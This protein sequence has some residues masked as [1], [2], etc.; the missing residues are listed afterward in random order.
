[1]IINH[2]K[3]AVRYLSKHRTY[4][5]INLLGLSL[6]YLC[7]LMLNIYVVGERNYDSQ[8]AHTYRLIQKDLSDEGNTIEVATIG[9]RV[10][11]ASR[12]QFPEI[13]AVT[14]VGSM[15]RLTVGNEP[16]NLHYERFFTIDSGFFEVFNFQF[17]EGNA[18]QLNNQPN[19]LLLT[20]TLKEKYFGNRPALGKLL[21]T[22]VFEGVVG[23]VIEDFPKNT[24]F[25]ANLMIPEQTTSKI[26]NWYDDFIS[27]S[28]HRNAFLTYF[29]LRD[30]SDVVNLEKKITA[31][32]EENWPVEEKFTSQF[33]LQDVRDIHLY[34]EQVEGEI[35]HQKGN[36]FYVN[37]FFWIG[38]LILLVATFNY[39]GLL[40]MAFMRRS[41]EIGIRKAVGAGKRQL[42]AQLLTE[43][44]LL[45]SVSLLVAWVALYMINPFIPDFF[46]SSF[47]LIALPTSQVLLIGL[48]GIVIS[49]LAIG[50]PSYLV[51]VRNIV[52]SLKGPQV[53]YPRLS[54][55][56]LLI[57]FQF[58]V[59]I[60][61][62]AMTTLLFR[63]VKYLEEKELG[64]NMEGL[65]VVDIN[66]GN[67]RSKFASIKEEFL[68]LPAVQK[69][70]VSSRVPGEW[71]NFPLVDVV[72]SGES[73]PTA[74]QM[75]FIGV[76]QDFIST[77]DINLVQGNNFRGTEFDSTQVL[78]NQAAVSA[79]GLIDPVGHFI[80]I[81][82]VNWSGDTNP[83][84]EPL[85][86]SIAGIVEDFHFEGFQQS[87]QPM[88]MGY[89]K[90][91]I[92]NIDYYSLS[93]NTSNWDA[94]LLAL[95]KINNQFD[96]ENPLE[97]HILND[98]F[99]RFHEPVIQRSQLLLF[100]TWVVVFIAC[101]GLFATTAYT[102][103]IRRKEIGI[104]K[105]LG[106]KVTELIKMISFDFL[107]LV[108][109]G[110][111]IALPLSWM[112]MKR[113][114][115]EFAYR[116]S[117]GWDLFALA[118]MLALFIAAITIA[119]Q[120]VRAAMENPVQSIRDE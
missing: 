49:L 56:K 60:S 98:Q 41:T 23:A 82:Q 80:E 91:P 97:Y 93:V 12:E 9:P 86:V 96:A 74:R 73:S 76:D 112:M 113:W 48:S 106:A 13:E 18:I 47:D 72:T 40:N 67:L 36:I 43:S 85:K 111:L 50:Y 39:T 58:V 110:G 27:T 54:S 79:L 21:K 94:T 1:M 118:G 116:V 109:I 71:K 70:S 68:R 5:L 89:W 77:Y 46:G 57:V 101:L 59:A 84:D 61:L 63:Q 117:I 7:F 31:L 83:L 87:I 75:I 99:A 42:L 2:I 81:P 11:Y 6:G 28:W 10:G 62:I 64:F 45:T 22:N 92:H 95:Q 19:G 29:K 88:V 105:V 100:F 38:I 53:G 119:H 3:V 120:S 107:K 15:G 44:L 78:L 115:D 17:I 108:L 55:R 16:T 14:E 25:H 66:S 102:L 26:F 90:N 65:V 103:Q 69:V 35:N 20:R 51:I 104:R 37:L 32:A 33:V 34:P 114:L 30:D 24:H 52:H 4:L 8:H